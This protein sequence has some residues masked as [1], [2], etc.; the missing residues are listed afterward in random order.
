MESLN[1][2]I[3][4]VFLPPRLPQ[5]D[6][7][8]PQHLLATVRALRDSVSAFLSMG[9]SEVRPAPAVGSSTFLVSE[10]LAITITLT[11]ESIV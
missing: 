6:D 3:N 9:C 10:I 4:H 2:M 7:T 1:F 5:E 11:R 8:N